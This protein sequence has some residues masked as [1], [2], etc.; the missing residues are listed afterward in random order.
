MPSP[1][2]SRRVTQRDIARLAG[3][4]QTTVS[5][6][7]NNRMGAESRIPRETR[8][9]VLRVIEETG[10]V[11]AP[12]P[13]GPAAGR[14]RIIGVFTY[15]PVF[16]SGPGDR[17][18]PFLVGI[19]EG[20]GRAGCHLL[21]LTGTPSMH[22]RER[23]HRRDHRL[24]PADGL[25]LLGREPDP[26]DLTGLAAEG[27]PFVSVGRRDDVGAP[28]SWV[29]ADYPAAVRALAARARALG[30]ERLAYLGH[31]AGPESWADR[32][33]GFEE[34]TAGLRTLRLNPGNPA[35]VLEAGVT[36]V[37][38]EDHAVAVAV[39]EAAARRGLAVPGDLSIV[40]LGD[41]AT[42]GGPGF[43]GLRVPREEMGRQA[44]EILTGLLDGGPPVRRLLP[45]A[46]T[47]GST[48]G[49]PATRW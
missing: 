16:P 4:S 49:S 44:V 21:L 39:A 47:E 28:I 43:T 33:R 5:L 11:A 13:R 46:L 48:L 42:P 26:E 38:A 27:H 10:Y 24:R 29:G 36:A 45:C 18:H 15:E 3:V 7:L 14:N 30:H 34:G 40:A 9:R 35:A 41:P 25:V 17:Y 31:G 22:G 20:A 2:R 8:D 6:V 37:F 32:L 12:A 19:E 23:A 1:K